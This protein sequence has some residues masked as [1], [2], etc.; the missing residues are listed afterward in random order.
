MLLGSDGNFAG[1]GVFDWDWLNAAGFLASSAKRIA[2][3]ET[4]SII[5]KNIIL[6]I[7]SSLS[8]R[9]YEFWVVKKEIIAHK[10]ALSIISFKPA[11]PLNL[12]KKQ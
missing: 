1:A 10:I 3:N 6:F 7:F 5:A 4:V 2:E 11:K 12:V 8:L 9:K